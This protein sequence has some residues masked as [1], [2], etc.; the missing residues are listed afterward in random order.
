MVFNIFSSNS[1]ISEKCKCLICGN[2]TLQIIFDHG[3]YTDHARIISSLL[4][5]GL[6][7]HPNEILTRLVWDVLLTDPST[8]V[9]FRDQI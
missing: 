1:D 8:V 2:Y 5:E 3:N 4:L 9:V 7:D 6:P